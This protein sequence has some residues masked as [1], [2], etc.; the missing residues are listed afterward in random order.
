SD[1]DR[2]SLQPGAL[3]RTPSTLAGDDAI[4]RAVSTH[5]NRL[6]DAVRFDR[7]RQ[8]LEPGIVHRQSWL[9]LIWREQVD[10][11]LYGPGANRLWRIGNQGTQ[12][13][14]ESGTAFEHSASS[15]GVAGERFLREGP[16]S[17]GS[18]R[19]GIVKSSGHAV[20]WRLTEF[21]VARDDGVENFLFEELPNIAGDELA[22]SGP[23]SSA[24]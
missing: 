11:D 2:H 18:A 3:R 14:S 5:E 17:G 13:F 6:N 19:L 21:H 23:V 10:V 16:V 9:V 20:A 15:G 12:P 24:E 7:L 1:D 8:L 22:Q 4:S